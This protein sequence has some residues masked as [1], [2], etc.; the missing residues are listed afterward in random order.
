MFCRLL[1]CL[2]K[3]PPPQQQKTTLLQLFQK[4]KR[5]TW[6]GNGSGWEGEANGEGG[7]PRRNR[8]N[9]ICKSQVLEQKG[10]EFRFHFLV[11]IGRKQ[12]RIEKKNTLVEANDTKDTVVNTINSMKLSKTNPRDNSTHQNVP[13]TRGKTTVRPTAQHHRQPRQRQQRKKEHRQL[14]DS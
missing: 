8:L 11:E 6:F 14:H 4:K 2:C 9:Y 10:A 13:K 1:F 5:D 7:M 3:S 12:Q